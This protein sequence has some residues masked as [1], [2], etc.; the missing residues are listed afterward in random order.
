M[1]I[2]LFNL[3]FW[4]IKIPSQSSG[5]GKHLCIVKILEILKIKFRKIQK[6]SVLKPDLI[7]A[8]SLTIAL[9]HSAIK[10]D[11]IHKTI[12]LTTNC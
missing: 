1:K 10:I 7:R 3:N 8:V 6:F 4:F 2:F 5:Q 12:D 11:Q 9:D